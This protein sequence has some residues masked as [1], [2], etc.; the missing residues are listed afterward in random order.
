VIASPGKFTA[1]RKQAAFGR[2]MSEWG[3]QISRP[4]F[5]LFHSA[6]CLRL[7][8]KSS[9]IRIEHPALQELLNKTRGFL[10][11]GGDVGPEVAL[12]LQ[13]VAELTAR[14]PQLRSEL[15]PHLLPHVPAAIAA[16]DMDDLAALAFAAASLRDEEPALWGQVAPALDALAGVARFLPAPT[17]A[18]LAATLGRLQASEVETIN[19]MDALQAQVARHAGELAPSDLAAA[20][21]GFGNHD[22]LSDDMQAA[23]RRVVVDDVPQWN[24]KFIDVDLTRI[25]TVYAK[26]GVRNDVV[27]K[28]VA[29]LVAS[30]SVGLEN[31]CS[32]A[33]AALTW[34]YDAL[35]VDG[36]ALGIF[37]GSL[38]RLAARRGLTAEQ[39]EGS[40]LGLDGGG[41]EALA[42]LWKADRNTRRGTR[43]LIPFEIPQQPSWRIHE[44]QKDFGK[45]LELKMAEIYPLR[46]LPRSGE[47][48][49][50]RRE[51]RKDEQLL[52]MLGEGDG[53]RRELLG[54]GDDEAD[55]DGL[56][57]LLGADDDEPEAETEVDDDYDEDDE[58]AA[59][60]VAGDEARP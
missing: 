49:E 27:L 1:G 10:A 56:L 6:K 58:L 25:I 13:A 36:D 46:L 55:A 30:D 21:W 31:L 33:V 24:I 3:K 39:I 17:A 60:D 40:R 41:D 4:E 28:A 47:T 48:P 45:R 18:R 43:K 44:L 5:A 51:L 19:V 53:D 34:S 29:R 14:V 37:R 57:A 12:M 7:L 32:W 50:E 54:A 15:L 20:V 2:M 38:H 42:A 59:L 16:A 52:N 22:G 11:A 8:P 23:L 35:A 26:L 9:G